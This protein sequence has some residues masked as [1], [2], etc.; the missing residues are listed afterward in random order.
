MMEEYNSPKQAKAFVRKTLRIIKGYDGPLDVTL[1]INCFIGLLIIPQQNSLGTHPDI[2]PQPL[3]IQDNSWGI[4]VESIDY[5]INDK[6]AYGCHN[7]AH[8]IAKHIRNSLCHHNRF[9]IESETGEEITHIVFKDYSCEQQ[10]I[11]T[12]T[13]ELKI[14]VDELNKFVIK[15]CAWFLEYEF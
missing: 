10:N 14:R 5:G 2:Y 11:D 7:N 15:Y 13:F 8:T 12:K 4:N 9:I 6:G 1:R 3:L